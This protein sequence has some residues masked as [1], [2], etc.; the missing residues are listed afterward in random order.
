MTHVARYCRIAA[1]LLLV[2]GCSRSTPEPA[3]ENQQSTA[4]QG[5]LAAGQAAEG[6][7]P[8]S[9]DPEQDDAA[10][11]KRATERRITFL[12]REIEGHRRRGY[13]AQAVA[14]ARRD[15]ATLHRDLRPGVVAGV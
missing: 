3:A 7:A 9:P 1:L 6:N 14:G 10:D 4:T 11:K 2:V 12:A 13:D 5:T 8:G 15:V